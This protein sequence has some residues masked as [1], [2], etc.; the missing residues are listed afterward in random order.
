MPSHTVVRKYIKSSYPSFR[1]PRNIA[2]VS[3]ANLSDTS[4]KILAQQLNAPRL[5]IGGVMPSPSPFCTLSRGSEKTRDCAKW[6]DADAGKSQMISA[7]IDKYGASLG[8][9]CLHKRSGRSLSRLVRTSQGLE[10]DRNGLQLQR[11]TVGYR[12]RVLG[13]RLSDEECV[14][15]ILRAL[16]ALRRV[17]IN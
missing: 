11:Y 2:I 6:R 16:S 14:S 9:P 10:G 13:V 3:L 17:R 8:K 12:I 7:K 1:A 4:R 15:S 5:S